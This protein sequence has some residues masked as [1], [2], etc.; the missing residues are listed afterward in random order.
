MS[1]N[2]EMKI[3]K[4]QKQIGELKNEA[5]NLKMSNPGHAV[6][7]A[8]RACEAICTHI[9]FKK[10]LIK[11]RRSQNLSS[12]I[13]LISQNGHVP[14]YI[15]DDIRFIQKK[16]N[17][18]VHST[19]KINPEDAEPVLKA[20]ANLVNWYFSGTTLQK[21]RTEKPEEASKV[22]TEIDKESFIEIV[23][24][25]FEKPW[26][27]TTAVTVMGATATALAAK[28]LKK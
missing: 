16:G 19:E 9:C 8:R 24:K 7:N 27:K 12:M 23:K 26:F 6:F 22:T 18:V 3:E 5:E 15:L 2:F 20:L 14:R 1:N 11:G 25:T 13:N 10:G 4:L 17:T 21:P 28:G